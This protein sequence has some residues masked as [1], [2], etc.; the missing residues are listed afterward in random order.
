M[1]LF[2]NVGNGTKQKRFVKVSCTYHFISIG[3]GEVI[4]D[5]ETM[6]SG[7]V[8]RDFETMVILPVTILYHQLVKMYDFVIFIF[9]NNLPN[10]GVVLC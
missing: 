2:K 4:K 8:I 10:E 6:V 5:F 9:D 1:L 7:E 3:F